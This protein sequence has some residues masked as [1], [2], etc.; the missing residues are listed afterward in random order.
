MMEITKRIKE[1]YDNDEFQ[2]FV[3]EGWNGYGKT[4]YANKSIAEVFSKDGNERN[5][6]IG[7]FRQHLGFHPIRVLQN[8]DS[9]KN[10]DY[11]FHWDDAGAWLHSLDFNNPYVKQV[12]KYLQTARTDWGVLIFSCI[13]A[14]DIIKKVRA[15]SSMVK[16]RITKNSTSAQP[17]RRVATAKHPDK[18][19]Y[20]NIHW[21]DDWTEEFTS[22]VPDYFYEW[23]NPLR[24]KY[25][26]MTKKLA[27]MKARQEEEIMKTLRY[28]EL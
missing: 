16:I 2:V 21:I 26:K 27:K 5:W 11:C 28:A 6:N 3:I 14:D 7:L 20:G 4:T 24:R 8:W 13:D 9:M 1:N 10:R 25:A 19:W 17:Y 15:F 22:H 12:G 18:D 23:Y